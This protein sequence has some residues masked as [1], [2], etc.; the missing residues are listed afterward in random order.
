VIDINLNLCNGCVQ[1]EQPQCVDI[2]PGDLLYIAPDGKAAIREVSE[3]WDCFACVKACPRLAIAIQLPFQINESLTKLT[4][5]PVKN[6]TVWEFRE[7]DGTVV[8]RFR[9]PA[10]NK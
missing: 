1:L 4:G 3:C 7:Q 5:H 6:K 8:H 10:R 9:I 2:C